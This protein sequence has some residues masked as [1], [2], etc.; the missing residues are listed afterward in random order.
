RRHP[1]RALLS[2][3]L[4]RVIQARARRT[5]SSGVH[6]GHVA[7]RDR[8]RVLTNRDRECWVPPRRRCFAGP[9]NVMGE[10]QE[11]LI[12][13]WSLL[14]PRLRLKN[15][16]LVAERIA[17]AAIDAVAV[18]DRLL[19]ELHAFAAQPLVGAE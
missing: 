9:L 19:R 4:E 6:L 5:P 8:I 15:P 12:R 10:L 1:L 14:T 2:G 7:G 16:D 17:E 13:L 3:Q 11:L 18:I